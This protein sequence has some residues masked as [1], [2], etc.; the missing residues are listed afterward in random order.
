MI[1]E[2]IDNGTRTLGIDF[3]GTPASLLPGRLVSLAMIA[4][5]SGIEEIV[6]K[7]TSIISSPVHDSITPLLNGNRLFRH[8]TPKD[9]EAGDD[10]FGY[11]LVCMDEGIL[12]L[13]ETQNPNSYSIF[14]HPE[15]ANVGTASILAYLITNILGFSSFLSFEVRFGI[16]EI[17][18]NIIEHGRLDG[19]KHWVRVRLEKNLN[20]LC[21][22]IADKGVE[23]DPTRQADFDLAQAQRSGIFRGLGLALTKKI[24]QLLKYN[25]DKGCNYTFF[26]K[27]RFQESMEKTTDGER[28]M[29]QFRILEEEET[30][31]SGVRK[32]GLAGDIDSMGALMLEKLMGRLLTNNSLNIEFDFEKVSFVSSTGIGV[33]LGIVSSIRTEGGDVVFSNVSHKILSILK[34]LNLDEYFEINGAS[35]IVSGG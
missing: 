1:L 29:T 30:G 20:K 32:I 21:V 5:D 28:V 12:C 22:S 26:E 35:K 27:A 10:L 16:Y 17:L 14:F 25:R 3:E 2:F 11:R 7:G 4:S 33:L 19:S 13:G 15:K 6:Y 18:T 9:Q 31:D 8:A 24:T 34:L 23:F